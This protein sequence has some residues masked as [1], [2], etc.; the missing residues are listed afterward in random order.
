MLPTTIVNPYRPFGGPRP[1]SSVCSSGAAREFAESQCVRHNAKFRHGAPK[2]GLRLPRWSISSWDYDGATEF[3]V[4]PG[5][6]A[7]ER[8]RVSMMTPALEEQ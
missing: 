6:K 4:M 3:T 2:T 7:L 5:A 1:I 8:A